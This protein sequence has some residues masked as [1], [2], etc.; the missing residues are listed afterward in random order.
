MTVRVWPALSICR[1]YKNH[2]EFEFSSAKYVQQRLGN[3][4]KN[5]SLHVIPPAISAPYLAA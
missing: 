3:P 5:Y 1:Q 2:P 4:P